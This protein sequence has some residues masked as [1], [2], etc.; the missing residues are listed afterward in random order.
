MKTKIKEYAAC[1]ADAF[2]DDPLYI[3]L[4]P[5]KVRY[6]FLKRLFAFR[7]SV[8]FKKDIIIENEHKKGMC[9]LRD[10]RSSYGF[11]DL[12]SCTDIWV[13][14]T[15]YLL[16]TVKV[17]SFAA[18]ADMSVFDEKTLLVWP[19][20]VKKQYQ[21]Q[22]ICRDLLKKAAEEAK[23]RGFALGL[24]TQ[25]ETNEKIYKRLGF[26]TQKSETLKGGIK[27]FYMKLKI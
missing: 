20:F 26:E 14:F 22:G 3:S 12:F 7:F 15:K 13:L 21:N 4:L 9:V 6:D 17:L 11:S 24:E 18:K 16:H 5:E 23:S 8:S 19:V 25:S 27:N 10:K 2:F 1:A